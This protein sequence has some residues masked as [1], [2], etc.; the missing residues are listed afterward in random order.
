[1]EKDRF[2][3][4]RGYQIRFQKRKQLTPAMEDYIEMI[5]RESL[6]SPYTRVNLL[7][8]LLN[9]KA[10]STTKMLQKLKEFGLV[11]YQKYGVVG[12]TEKGKE[13]GKFLLDRH[14]TVEEF[15]KNLGVKERLLEQTELIEHN[16]SIETLEKMRKFNRFLKENPEI[17][18]KYQKSNP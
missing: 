5:Y 7:S 17:K 1:M 16:I 8:E 4:V 10:P 12:L 11:E 15:L 6:K 3:T 2:Y 18:E 9:V 14:F 13:M